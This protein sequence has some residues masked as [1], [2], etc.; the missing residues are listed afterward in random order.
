[1][2]LF[3]QKTTYTVNDINGERTTLTLDKLTADLLPTVVDDVHGFLER[4]FKTEQE[5]S[6]ELSRLGQGNH[7]RK[8]CWKK[9]EYLIDF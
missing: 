1:M 3:D 8:I 4:T 6:P 9:V 2:N 7:V 5:R